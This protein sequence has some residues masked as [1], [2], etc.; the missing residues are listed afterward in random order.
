MN[1]KLIF[2]VLCFLFSFLGFY[3]IEHLFTVKPHVISGN[4][5]LGILV[6]LL[7]TPVFISSWVYTFK[8]VNAKIVKDSKMTIGILVFSLA[9]CV[10]LMIEMNDYTGELI[11]ALGGTPDNPESRIYRFGWFNQYTNSLYFN[12]Y[13]FFL[14]HIITVIL[15]IL[16]AMRRK[17]I[18]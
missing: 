13:T 18:H 7:F 1:I 6:I 2:W 4:G 14:S 15:G 16:S 17:K 9:C 5:N 3:L 10:L 8:L 12:V 11:T